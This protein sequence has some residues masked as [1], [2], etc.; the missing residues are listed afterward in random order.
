MKESIS[1]TEAAQ[2]LGISRTAVLKAIQ[3]GRIKAKKVGNVYIIQRAN[4]SIPSDTAISD[5]QK[6]FIESS[7][8]RVVKEYGETLKMLKDA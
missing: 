8:D 5:I 3:V 6:R 2:L 4:L 1:V 7:V